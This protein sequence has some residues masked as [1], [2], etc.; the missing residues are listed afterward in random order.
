MS[1]LILVVVAAVLGRLVRLATP[2]LLQM[3][4]TTMPFRRPG[5]EAVAVLAFLVLDWRLG[6]APAQLPWYLFA[7]LLLAVGSAD[8][9]TK[10][11]PT[12]VCYVGAVLGVACNFAYPDRI[13]DLLNQHDLAS[14]AGL[15][16]YKPHQVGIALA[17][18]GAVMGFVLIHFIRKV[19]RPMVNVEVMGSGDALLMLLIGAFIGPRAVLYSLLPACLVGIAV[20]TVTRLVFKQ[21]HMALAPHWPWRVC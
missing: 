6:H 16:I 12:L 8:A 7:L 19:F 20:G 14:L 13:M 2:R 5:V 11:I 9:Y 17:L 18:S 1:T 4:D 21:P 10:Y 15:S 3:S